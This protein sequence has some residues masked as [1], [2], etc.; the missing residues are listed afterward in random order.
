MDSTGFLRLTQD[1]HHE[2]LESSF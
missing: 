1:R 2:R